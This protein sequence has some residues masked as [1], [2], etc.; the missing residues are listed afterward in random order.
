MKVLFVLILTLFSLGTA[1]ANTE[2]VVNYQGVNPYLLVFKDDEGAS[3]RAPGI[4]ASIDKDWKL[5]FPGELFRD[6]EFHGIFTQL[7]DISNQT[8]NYES[9]AIINGK[10]IL[11]NINS[12]FEDENSFIDLS[13]KNGQ[14]S[15]LASGQQIEVLP[16]TNSRDVT[17]HKINNSTK[18]QY[19]LLFSVKQN[20][21]GL[22]TGLTFFL[23]LSITSKGPL[24]TWPTVPPMVIDY[25]YKPLSE[26]TSAVMPSNAGVRLYSENLLRRIVNPVSGLKTNNPHITEWVGKVKSALQ[27]E[28]KSFYANILPVFDVTEGKLIFPELKEP[29][30]GQI[31]VQ[32]YDPQGIDHKFVRRTN[33]EMSL[34]GV[35]NKSTNAKFLYEP[36]VD[37]SAILVINND[38]VVIKENMMVLEKAVP[39]LTDFSAHA[40]AIDKEKFYYLISKKGLPGNEKNQTW[41]F[42]VQLNKN[43]EPAH[44]IGK[45]LLNNEYYSKNELQKR[46]MPITLVQPDGAEKPTILFDDN[47]KLSK[48]GNSLV[49]NQQILPL[50]N[51][52]EITP[53]SKL[54]RTY[55]EALDIINLNPKLEYRKYAEFDSKNPS[56]LYLLAKEYDQSV[57]LIKRSS[58]S[59][60][61]G[62]LLQ[63]ITGEGTEES[64]LAT[65]DKIAYIQTKKDRFVFK[66]E[67]YAVDPDFSNGENGFKLVIFSKNIASPIMDFSPN[68]LG[69]ANYSPE[70]TEVKIPVAFDRVKGVK[71]INGQGDK[72]NHVSVLLQIEADPNA[73]TYKES[74]AM[75]RNFVLGY[76]AETSR[77]TVVPEKDV[78][79]ISEDA[80]SVDLR[81]RLVYDTVS[82]DIYWVEKPHLDRKDKA[83][84]VASLTT[85]SR[86]Y[87]N[88]VSSKTINLDFEN[89]YETLARLSDSDWSWDK[90]DSSWKAAMSTMDTNLDQ[91]VGQRM[92]EAFL[93]RHD[94]E[95][96][97]LM[98]ELNA[99]AD[100]HKSPKRTIF[101]V[102]SNDDKTKLKNYIR[103]K[104]NQERKGKDIP[105]SYYEHNL[106]VYVPQSGLAQWDDIEENFLAINNNTRKAVIYGDI[107]EILKCGKDGRLT[108]LTVDNKTPFR[109]EK[110]GQEIPPHM[111]YLLSTEGEELSF[112]EFAQKKNLYKKSAVYVAT[113]DEMEKL[114][115]SMKP[116]E[117]LGLFQTYDVNYQY[118]QSNWMVKKPGPIAKQIQN[119]E[120]KLETVIEQ[121]KPVA[122]RPLEK[123][124]FASLANL[125]TDV[126]NPKLAPSTK[127]IIVDHNLKGIIS[128]TILTWWLTGSKDPE[129]AQFAWNH[130][131]ENL[132]IYRL[133][134]I[135]SATTGLNTIEQNFMA[136]RNAM[137][138]GKLPVLIA[139]VAVIKELGRVEHNILGDGRSHQK[140]NEK[141]S[142]ML[143][144]FVQQDEDAGDSIL[145]EIAEE[146]EDAL[147][148]RETAKEKKGK[149][150][151]ALWWLLSEGQQVKT[152]DMKSFKATMPKVLIATAEEWKSLESDVNFEARFG[153]LE[154]LEFMELEAPSKESIKKVVLEYFNSLEFNSLNY[155]FEYDSNIT[156]AEAKEVMAGYL[157][158]KIISLSTQHNKNLVLQFSR[159]L[160][161][162]SKMVI[163]DIAVRNA[164][165]I[166]QVV[167]NKLFTRVFNIPLDLKTLP[168]NDPLKVIKANNGE[169][170]IVKLQEPGKMKKGY[171][172][173]VE[174]K[175][176]FAQGLTKQLSSG[177]DGVNLPNAFIIIGESGTGKTFLVDKTVTDVLDLKEYNYAKP[178]EKG[179]QFFRLAMNNVIPDP[180]D[181][182]VEDIR[183]D[184][185][186]NTKI[187]VSI[188]LKHLDYALTTPEGFRMHV[189]IDDIHKADPKVIPKILSFIKSLQEAPEGIYQTEVDGNLA[190]TPVRN[191]T[192]Y[193]TLNPPDDKAIIQKY[194]ADGD[195]IGLIVGAIAQSGAT[196]D[197]SVIKRFPTII[198]LQKFPSE[199]KAPALMTNLRKVTQE[200]F[201]NQGMLIL[202]QQSTPASIVEEFPDADAREFI[203]QATSALIEVAQEAEF[204]DDSAIRILISKNKLKKAGNEASSLFA[205]YALALNAKWGASGTERN[206]ILNFVGSNVLSLPV[207]KEQSLSKMLFLSMIVDNFRMNIFEGIVDSLPKSPIFVDNKRAREFILAPFLLATVDHAN[208]FSEFPLTALHLELSKLGADTMVQRQ[209]LEKVITSL[210][211]KGAEKKLF[212]MIFADE[213]I[214]DDM[215]ALENFIGTSTAEN[216]ERTRANVMTD[217]VDRIYKILKQLFQSYLRVS[218]VNELPNSVDW[219]RAVPLVDPTK[220]LSDLS[221]K[222]IEEY[223]TFSMELFVDELYEVKNFQEFK[224]INQYDK[225]RLFLSVIEKAMTRLPWEETLPF[226]I[227]G[228]QAAAKDI[229]LGQAVGVQ[230]FLFNS[231]F[232]PFRSPGNATLMQMIASSHLFKNYKK[233]VPAIKSTFESNCDKFFYNKYTKVSKSAE[234][235]E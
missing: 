152:Q 57:P 116:E 178:K 206:N 93:K 88:K 168:E 161:V 9:L 145:K 207:S 11:F 16:I 86:A 127:V 185:Y 118:F 187:P 229:D 106:H 13:G 142:F 230:Q 56:G 188:A 89:S 82:G 167:I 105:W 224:T 141:S 18:N 71:I 182:K 135:E 29:I 194:A 99:I 226:V 196:I 69:T 101:V 34:P 27:H 131:N 195:T 45:T 146:E 193:V 72:S 154:K 98:N 85:S 43:G 212:P 115:K 140:V 160:D 113:Y 217:S 201:N 186:T 84:S 156:Q 122:A 198:N 61:S 214:S 213:V 10:I 165:V 169:D 203:P 133:M 123:E 222:L 219:L 19:T 87:P 83:F 192:L 125:L 1:V 179:A 33:V 130:R 109:L 138:E 148:Y 112:N 155:R 50:L 58:L 153:A 189:L 231:Q 223:T 26:I 64:L 120:G 221:A 233:E 76:K 197:R 90:V 65:N 150:P 151:H 129:F 107:G 175:E 137:N 209:N 73:E 166:D 128:N 91:L 180:D 36:Q 199:A 124:I 225:A 49:R 40:I 60:A 67:A 55:I 158:N 176:M 119:K 80:L 114:K 35:V 68:G 79:I 218:D 74:S 202:A 177:V 52:S 210:S 77:L 234:G 190:E 4:Y 228:I 17:L 162:L 147:D 53:G 173:P 38:L 6:R 220:A 183:I 75:V 59:S 21:P 235:K 24:A 216:V 159:A 37:G 42:E 117:E 47:S 171:N 54:K 62:E 70:L 134:D 227:D 7:T 139:D 96:K 149:R 39:Q 143:Q 66:M 3:K 111:F 5:I 44:L 211:A 15:D 103:T 126:S 41:I 181:L 100:T 110:N 46:L 191:L 157:A 208:D 2:L 102:S 28:V 104:Y 132:N 14:L 172:G 200:Q 48:D 51:V 25:K 81:A 94:N 163:E 144:D 184:P 32:Y 8:Q 204:A 78:N 121:P 108:D 170:F 232:S 31:A 12:N 174:L 97:G 30:E 215:S 22:G 95:F 63:V 23:N 92:D 164:G 20:L 136:M 205:R